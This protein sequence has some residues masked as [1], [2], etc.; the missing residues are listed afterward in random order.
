MLD[1]IK[2]VNNIPK[3]GNKANKAIKKSME[4]F[5][6]KNIGSTISYN[7]KKISSNE[8]QARYFVDEVVHARTELFAIVMIQ[9]HSRWVK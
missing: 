7:L 1:I 9:G 2:K 4:Y 5:D 6:K 3:I 8:L